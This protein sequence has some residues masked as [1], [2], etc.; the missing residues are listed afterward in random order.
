MIWQNNHE[1]QSESETNTV[2][3]KITSNN[4]KNPAKGN[5]SEIDVHTLEKNF[6][7]KVRGEVD[8]VMT[9]V[10]NRVRDAILTAIESLVIPRVELAMKS[11]NASSGR[12][13][14]SIFFSF[15]KDLLIKKGIYTIF[16]ADH[17]FN[18]YQLM[19]K[20]NVL[21]LK[22]LETSY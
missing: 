7:N 22:S 8:S 21:T 10:E 20:V 3:E 13:E 6:A 2:E 1:V 12:D 19:Q 9:T 18:L 16:C 11:V 17:F 14:N 5:T 15:L 4:A